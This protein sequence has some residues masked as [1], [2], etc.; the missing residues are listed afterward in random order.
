MPLDRGMLVGF[1]RFARRS[2]ALV[3]LA[4]CGGGEDD[5]AFLDW[6]SLRNPIL[7]LEHEA[8]KG[9]AVAYDAPRR[10]FFLFSSLRRE[11]D[12]PA[13]ATAERSFFRSRD[14][15]HWSAS[16]TRT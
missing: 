3:L 2:L 5:A 9:V 10:E 8:V 13:F 6:E 11:L 14:L 12:D 16:P 7:A 1:L 15:A 4:G